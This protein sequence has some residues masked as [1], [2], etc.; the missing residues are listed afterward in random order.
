[1]AVLLTSTYWPY[2][3]KEVQDLVHRCA[4]LVSTDADSAVAFYESLDLAR[5]PVDTVV[6][7]ITRLYDKIVS[8]WLLQRDSLAEG[9]APKE[10][11]AKANGTKT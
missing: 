9:K 4:T 2:A 5:V 1:L 8:P 6:G 7:F 3:R 11:K 10:K